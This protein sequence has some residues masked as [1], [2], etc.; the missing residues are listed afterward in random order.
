M[1]GAAH[2]S[3]ARLLPA[4]PQGGRLNSRTRR[5]IV[6]VVKMGS[7]ELLWYEV[8]PVDNCCC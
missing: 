3:P 1:H 4:A 5:D 2:G 6:H 7:R 8:R